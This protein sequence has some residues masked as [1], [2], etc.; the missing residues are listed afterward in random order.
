MGFVLSRKHKCDFFTFANWAQF[1]MLLRLL[2]K[3][4]IRLQ[5]AGHVYIA[6]AVDST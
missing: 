5:T 4:L 2:R 1:Y 3:E 6:R